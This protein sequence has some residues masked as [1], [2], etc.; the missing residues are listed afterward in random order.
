MEWQ[1]W[2]LGARLL[3]LPRTATGLLLA[4]EVAMGSAADGVLTLADLQVEQPAE[5]A[6]CTLCILSTATRQATS[7]TTSTAVREHLGW[8]ERGASVRAPA[9]EVC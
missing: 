6:E 8:R 1:Q 9:G 4:V 3:L 2:W 5:A 7:P